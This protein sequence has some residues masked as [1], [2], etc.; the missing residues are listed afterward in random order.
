MSD[1]TD[2]TDTTSTSSGTRTS[3]P[4]T[5]Q[6]AAS[7]PRK[8][9]ADRKTKTPAP[10]PQRAARATVDLDIDREVVDVGIDFRP[11]PVRLGAGDEHLWLFNPDPDISV[12]SAVTAAVDG[13][14]GIKPEEIELS[15][16]Q[17][18]IEEIRAAIAA[19]LMHEADQQAFL[20]ERRYGPQTLIKLAAKLTQEVTGFPTT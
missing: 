3:R 8:A 6:A 17:E 19:L 2:T 20:A 16:I 4:L 11:I 5:P 10:A 14:Q 18:T 12:W 15:Q 7:R 9:P 1:S 13:Y